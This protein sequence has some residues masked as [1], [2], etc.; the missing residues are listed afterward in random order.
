MAISDKV[1][2]LSEAHQGKGYDYSEAV[3][4]DAATKVGV[5]CPQHGVFWQLPSNHLKGSGCPHCA[6]RDRWKGS[7]KQQC[8]ELG[9]DYWRALKRREAGMSEWKIL[10][11]GYVRS[12]KVTKTAVTVAGV[13]YPS[14]RAACTA[15]R[16]P[17]S[18][19]TIERWIGKG[20]APE[21]AFQRVPNPGYRDGLIYCVTHIDSGARYV[22]LTIQTLARRWEDHQEQA[23]AG[24]I[25]GELSL[26]AAIRLHGADAFSIEQIDA[27]CTKVD[28]EAKER[29]WIGR[30]GTMAPSG[31][32][33]DPG[34]VSGGS[35]A[36]PVSLDGVHYRSV[37][38]AAQA[39]AEQKG[40]SLHAASKR[41][42]AGRVHIKTPAKPGE[43]LVKTKAYKAWSAM[44]HVT[45]NPRSKD[46]V[47]GVTLHAPWRTFE[48]FLADVGQPASPELCFARK[49]KSQGF[50]PENCCWMTK[51][52]AS[53]INAAHMKAEGRLTGRK[54]KVAKA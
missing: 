20:M 7:F 23:A 49:D 22:G 8:K 2:K 25:Q 32:N 16:P 15:L 28:L 37:G 27:G 46:H 18:E 38:E 11:E 29:L 17:A 35:S 24:H 54:P 45:T 44:V 36:K 52:E 33:L 4:V 13:F 39:L 47:A 41:L 50:T 31:F 53:K 30:L 40:I 6:K 42:S 12:E 5:K 10:A 3:Y 26:H 34:G 1:K 48:A 14:I 19:T 51:S 43:S 21:D 9:I